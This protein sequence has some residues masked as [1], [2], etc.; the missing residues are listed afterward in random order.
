MLKEVGAQYTIRRTDI[1]QHGVIYDKGNDCGDEALI[2]LF[3]YFAQICISHII[4]HAQG[5]HR[6]GTR[7]VSSRVHFSRLFCRNVIR[8]GY[9]FLK[10]FPIRGESIKI[11]QVFNI[12][13]DSFYFVS[14][15]EFHNLASFYFR[16]C[17]RYRFTFH[18]I[19]R[20]RFIQSDIRS[21]PVSCP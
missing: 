15:A 20:H 4:S 13:I 19:I 1:F 7:K 9:S 17:C 12:A 8:Q 18:F 21:S 3:L 5:G 14:Q 2:I 6:L 11:Q 16:S 10:I